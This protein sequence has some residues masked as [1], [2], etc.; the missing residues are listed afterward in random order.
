MSEAAETPVPEFDTADLDQLMADDGVYI[1]KGDGD[2]EP[3]PQPS[4]APS[5]DTAE[6]IAGLLVIT[7]N[8]FAAPRFGEHWSIS[9]DEAT[10]LGEAYDAV[11]SK[12]F[13]DMA[14]GPE[15][16]AVVATLGFIL[17]RTMIHN[18]KKEQATKANQPEKGSEKEGEDGGQ[19]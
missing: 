4:A 10:A 7:F 19:A 14:V 8:K 9:G 17:P 2:T 16:A 18:A 12:Y 15:G 13:P 5:I 11:L 1:P 3:D 6:M